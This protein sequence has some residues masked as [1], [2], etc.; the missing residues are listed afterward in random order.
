MAIT[1]KDNAT[2]FTPAPEGLHQ[3][4]C[5]D[6]IDLGLLDT[7]WGKRRKVVIRWQINQVNQ[8]T[9]KRFIA[10]KRYT[11]SLNKK[12][13]LYKDLSA[14]RGKP[15]TKEECEGFDL[16]LLLDKNCQL[17]IAHSIGDDGT[18]YAN[19]QTIVPLATGQTKIRTFEYVREKDR[20]DFPG[21]GSHEAHDE[22]DAGAP[23]F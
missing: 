21:N 2:S 4:V 19:V 17:Q 7:K 1:V 8:D 18:K 22:D 20:T 10:Q 13:S 15:M 3:G 23:A 11:A 14:W 16:E 12:A 5:V 6:I 9:G